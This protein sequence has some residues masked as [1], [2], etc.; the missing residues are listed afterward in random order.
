MKTALLFSVLFCAIALPALGELSQQDLDKIRLVIKEEIRE[1]L[2]PIKSDIA[3]MKDDISSLKQDVAR[4]DGLLDGIQEQVSHATNITYG[5]IALIVAAIGIPQ[6]II[7]SRSGRDH[8]QNRRIE[9]LRQEIE[10]LK[11]QRIVNP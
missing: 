8:E 2:K 11:Q 6:I 1:E 9:E 10:T 4:L 3:S 5:L 7:A